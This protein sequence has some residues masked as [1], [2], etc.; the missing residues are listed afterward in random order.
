M[1]RPASAAPGAQHCFMRSLG[2]PAP[3]STGAGRAAGRAS[4]ATTVTATLL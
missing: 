2:I 3:T 1:P 4:S